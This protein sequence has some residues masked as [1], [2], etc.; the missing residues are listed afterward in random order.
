MSRS[1]TESSRERANGGLLENVCFTAF[2]LSD[3]S[4]SCLGDTLSLNTLNS[5]LNTLN[6]PWQ[7]FG[8]RSSFFAPDL[9]VSR[10]SFHVH[11]AGRI[12]RQILAGTGSEVR[13][14]RAKQ[15]H[16]PQNQYT[17]T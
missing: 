13:H 3:L 8:N 6:S 4:I 11:S 12:D 10:F 9:A 2:F 1:V 14:C 16:L 15:A 17:H 5:P 7:P